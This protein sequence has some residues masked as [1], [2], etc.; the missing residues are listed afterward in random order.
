MDTTQST[1]S[2]RVKI[3]INGEQ[4]TDFSN[5]AT[6]PAQNNETA[7][8]RSGITHAIGAE[9]YSGARRF[10]DGYIA[11]VNLVDGQALTPADFGET[12][13]YGEWKP[14]EYSGTYG[15]NGFYL[16][17]KNDYTVEG[18]S[19]VTYKGSGTYGNYIGGTG[20]NPDI[21]WIKPRSLADNHQFYD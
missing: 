6:Y 18:F 9:M 12:G 13:D 19:T 2:N 3:Y 20:F 7:V 15:T 16:P 11:E 1:A 21:I 10:M 4:V 8:N 14:K 17:F 5:S